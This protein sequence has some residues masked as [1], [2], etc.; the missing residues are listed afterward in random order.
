MYTCATAFHA[1]QTGPTGCPPATERHSPDASIK[2]RKKVPEL[3]AHL[4]RGLGAVLSARLASDCGGPPEGLAARCAVLCA[5]R[6][7]WTG[8]LKRAHPSTCRIVHRSAGSLLQSPW[9][10]PQTHPTP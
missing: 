8:C 7:P 9:P 4:A 6:A 3:K 5:L 10:T 1:R 2:A